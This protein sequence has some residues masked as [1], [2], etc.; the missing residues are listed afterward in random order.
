MADVPKRR[1]ANPRPDLRPVRGQ[2]EAVWEHFFMLWTIRAGVTCRSQ[3]KTRMALR[4]DSCQ[5]MWT[6]ASMLSVARGHQWNYKASDRTSL[7][8]DAILQQ[9]PKRFRF[10]ISVL[11]A[12][13]CSFSAAQVVQDNL[14]DVLRS[15]TLRGAAELLVAKSEA[16]SALS[17]AFGGG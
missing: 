5:F 13:F 7:L 1:Y 3:Y 17:S 2:M 4:L 16:P 14:S 15:R 8:Q 11:L 6:G 10:S 12:I 9:V